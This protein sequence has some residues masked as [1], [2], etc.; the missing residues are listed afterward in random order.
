MRSGEEK[1]NPVAGQK[2]AIEAGARRF[3]EGCAACHG[4]NA[5]GGRG[6]RLVQNRDLYRLTDQQIF[7]IVQ[8]GIPGTGMPPSQM[9]DDKTWQVVAFIRS[10]SSPASKAFVEGDASHGRQLFFGPG[11]CNTCHAIRGEGGL[12]APDL[13][14]AGGHLTVGE[15]RQSIEHPSARIETGF[16][17]VTVHL[18]NGSAI[19]G[20]AK[21]DSNYSIQVLDRKGA[22]H[23]ISKSNVS[24]IDWSNQSLMP[25]SVISQLGPS[26]VDDMMAFLAQQVIRPDAGNTPRRRFRDIH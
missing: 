15:L 21:N 5:E 23:L 24:G 4:A 17:G 26:G 12:I 20:V 18:K 7:Q 6:P 1:Q 10:L 3:R 13:S 14:D 22:L 11:G 2:P 19:E 16:R 8:K 25:N 9:P